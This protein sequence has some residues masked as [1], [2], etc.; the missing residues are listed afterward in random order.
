MSSSIHNGT[1][2]V[3][4]LLDWTRNWLTE[5]DIDEPRL[6][7]EL[8]LAESLSCAKIELY[9]RFESV[10]DEANRTRFR[11]LVQRAGANEPVAYLLGKR[12]FFSI[13]FEVTPAVLIPRPETETLVAAV[14]DHCRAGARDRWHLL[15]AGT[16][17][18]C[19]AVAVA[20]YVP[21]AH[22][23]AVDHSAE[24]LDVAGR[25]I[26][27]YG[28]CERVRPTRA[29]WLDLPDGIRPAEGFDLIMSNPPYIPT[30]TL[31]TL[32]ANVRDYEPT[33]ALDGG[34]DGLDAYRR[35]AAAAPDVLADGGSVFVEIGADQHDDVVGTFTHDGRFTHRQTRQDQAR[36]KRM[37]QFELT[38]A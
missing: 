24:A 27:R 28:L 34:A 21:E 7:A 20:Q 12:E 22:V 19:V 32:P 9:T 11:E 30:E 25:N 36:I 38:A 23:V 2:T 3:R 35:L 5:R 8:L 29:D 16:G 13:E 14:V 37:L 26:D 33:G 17:S 1:W 6:A 10:P 18:G 31:A 15:D 4:R